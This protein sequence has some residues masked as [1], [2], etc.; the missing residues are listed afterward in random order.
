MALAEAGRIEDAANFAE[1]CVVN[2]GIRILCEVS[3]WH[4]ILQRAKE[5]CKPEEAQYVIDRLFISVGPHLQAHPL[6]EEGAQTRP[7]LPDALCW[8]LLVGTYADAGRVNEAVDAMQVD[9]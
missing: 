7:A 1:K 4:R 3:T 9:R 6:E 8:A 5:L 2:K